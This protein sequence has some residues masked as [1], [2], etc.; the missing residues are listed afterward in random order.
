[1]LVLSRSPSNTNTSWLAN[2]TRLGIRHS[3]TLEGVPKTLRIL[4]PIRL[5]KSGSS[6]LDGQNLPVEKISIRLPECSK[7]QYLS[8]C[9][10]PAGSRKAAG[11]ARIKVDEC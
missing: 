6:P 9:N 3:R 4:S 5:R 8:V 1:M 11:Q 2:Y 7:Q 10:A